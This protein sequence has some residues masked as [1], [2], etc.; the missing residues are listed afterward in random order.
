VILIGRPTVQEIQD[1]QRDGFYDQVSKKDLENLGD[2]PA[3]KDEEKNPVRKQKEIMAGKQDNKD[4]RDRQHRTLTRLLCFDT[5]DLGDGITEDVMFW[6]LLEQKKLLKAVRLTEMYPSR[7]LRRPLSHRSFLPVQGRVEGISLLELV[8]GIHDLTKETIDMMIDNGTWA[9]SPMFAYRPSSSMKNERITVVPGDGIPLSDPQR[10]INMLKIGNENQSFGFN[11]L[12][13]A[14]QQLERVTLQGDIQSGRVPLGRS[15]ALRTQ[16]SIA[17]LLAQGEARPERVLRR[18]FSVVRDVYEWMHILNQSFLPAE[19]EFLVMGP[20]EPGQS[21]YRKIKRDDISG[22]YKFDF[23][24]NVLNSN[25]Q[26]LAESLQMVL[27][28]AFTPLGFQTGIANPDTLYKVLR[29]L[30]AASGLDP[31]K[32]LSRPSPDSNRPRLTAQDVFADLMDDEIP[33]GIPLESAIEHLQALAEIEMRPI[34][35]VGPDEVEVITEAIGLLSPESAQVLAQWK[36]Q[37]AERAKQEM[38]LQ[39]Q[40]AAAEG[41]QLGPPGTGPGRPPESIQDPGGNPP[42]Q[43]TELL[44]EALPTAR[45]QEGVA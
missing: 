30:Y 42:V 9:N 37:V 16:G 18:F 35:V 5:F 11:M 3:D 26:V 7:T 17:M 45:G 32:Y 40:M 29:D 22:E 39:A 23:H 19:K 28:T 38:A 27:T 6:V 14:Q 25:R 15:S 10:D 36:A 2:Q 43:G 41:G 1:L 12:A 20:L 8:E 34:K 13:I 44:D 31:D 24:A 33:N 21:E 4:P